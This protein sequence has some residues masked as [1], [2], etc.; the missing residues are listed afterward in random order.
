MTK[1]P[2]YMELEAQ[3]SVCAAEGDGESKPDNFSLAVY[4]GVPVKLPN[5]F[6][7]VIIN[8]KGFKFAKKVTPVVM[9]HDT[10]RRFGHTLEQGKD[11]N[12]TA[13][14]TRSSV[15]Q[16]AVE[17]AQDIQNGFPMQVSIGAD[18]TKAQEV[19]E[20]ETVTVNGQ[21]WEGPLLVAQKSVGREITLTTLGADGNTSVR[22]AASNSMGAYTMKFEQWV[23]ATTGLVFDDLSDKQKVDLQ[24]KYDAGVKAK[25]EPPP[26]TS[27][28]SPPPPPLPGKAPSTEDRVKASNAKIAANEV[29]VEAIQIVV[30]EN[31]DIELNTEYLKAEGV[32]VT[33]VRGLSAHAIEENW[34]PDKFELM[35]SRAKK[36]EVGHI[37]IHSKNSELDGQVVEA[38]LLRQLG[39]PGEGEMKAQMGDRL[40]KYS[41]IPIAASLG[42]MKPKFG[43]EAWYND[44]TLEA[45]DDR[46]YRGLSLHMLLD[47]TIRAHRGY[48]YSGNR[49][50]DD[51][52]KAAF[53][54][55]QVIKA[56]SGFS[57]VS[58][59]NILENVANKITMWM[60]QSQNTVWRFFCSIRSLNDFKVHSMYRMEGT[61]RYKKVGSSGE[62]RHGSLS[63]A[64]F[65]LQADTYGEILS[66]NRQQMRNDDMD[67][68]SQIFRVLGRD[69]AIA[70]ES[71]FFAL[72]L[73]NPGSFFAS[74]N[75]NLNSG[76]SSDLG[77]GGLTIMEQSA[78]DLV[79]SNGNPILSPLDRI[80]VGTQDAVLAGKLFDGANLIAV[81]MS[82]TADV[83]LPSNNE[84]V[85]KYQPFKS[86]YLNNTSVLDHQDGSAITGQD[87]DQW[88]GSGDPN[89]LPAF[90]IGFLDG[91][92]TPVMQ[93]A[94]SDFSHLG[95]QFR[96]YHDWGI[97]D[98]DTNGMIKMA[99]T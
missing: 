7:P 87:S 53:E 51:F 45:S 44:Q 23:A 40:V 57:T 42:G 75:N 21:E 89:T 35:L 24:A 72:L 4:T 85:G 17:A 90:N 76:A 34:T 3:V 26:T 58:V 62:L 32:T 63:D 88:Y 98:A 46:K 25:S 12:I 94:D 73:S 61:G 47:N 83:Q 70:P 8:I 43:I 86:P 60:F 59:S 55:D 5:F 13:K 93:S 99:G 41:D 2:S 18:I 22:I 39:V 6:V 97:G 92:Q 67:A 37:G 29:R 1:I 30:G 95:M 33:T 31:N 9:D 38:A 36:P 56:A 80:L 66:L 68:F 19:A 11:G 74:G 49:K 77:I 14:I 28:P 10:S 96:S 48:T 91:N 64:K 81:D 16:E 52:L 79:D 78:A 50:S 69:G 15:R 54:S 65:T 71:A 27:K 84:H 20:G 82:A